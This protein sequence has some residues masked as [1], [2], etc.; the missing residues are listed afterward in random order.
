MRWLVPGLIALLAFALGVATGSTGARER[1]RRV[2]ERAVGSALVAI[3][4]ERAS[5][6]RVRVL[7]ENPSLIS[8][9]QGEGAFGG[10][11]HP[12]IGL[13]IFSRNEEAIEAAR[14][15]TQVE[16]LAPR[17]WLIRLPVSNAALFET[18]KG[19]VLVDTGAAPAGPGLLDAIRSV[20]SA[21]LHT[22]IYTHGHVDHAYGTWALLEKGDRPEIVA[23]AALPRRFERYIRLRGSIAKYMSQ[24]VDTLPNGVE[25]L[26]W[27][28][29]TFE[30]RLE[31]EI[32]GETFVLQHHLGETDDQLYVWIAGRKALVCAD[33]C[34]EW[35]PNVENGKRVQRYVE[36][37]AVALRE[38][39]DLGAEILLPGH[40]PAVLETDAIHD[41]FV[42]LAEALESIVEQTIEGL[43]AGLRKDQVWARVRL[44]DHLASHPHLQ[45][46]YVSVQDVSKMVIKRY[47]GWWDDIPSHWSP[48]PVE[49]QAIA[50]V[51]SAGGLD[52][53]VRYA[54]RLVESDVVL[55][56][57][58]ADWA[59]LADPESAQ[60]QQ[61]IL[62]V[63]KQRILDAGSYTQEKLAYVDQM[64]AARR[65]QLMAE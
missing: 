21:P 5:D 33:Y 44:P 50:L 16:K 61:L 43:N 3:S 51:D 31:L 26:V 15:L 58:F 42:V 39:A 41:D 13:G 56:S 54:R 53:F 17:T 14:D 63:Y 22:I 19:L 40:G 55:A 27:P 10:R 23:H 36:E 52:A 25:D 30:D 12:S 18:D 6:V 35:I 59:F 11:S 2:G 37:W 64:A 38:M 49:A 34:Q 28:T 29:R 62:D 46:R 9:I 24:P 65:L 20:S 1:L 45:Q 32:G 57:H 8:A 4:P 7:M 48:A 47:T 60:A